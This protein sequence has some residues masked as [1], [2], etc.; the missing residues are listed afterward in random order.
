MVFVCTALG[1]VP[2]ITGTGG[3][4]GNLKDAPARAPRR[5][6]TVV[7][8]I[9]ISVS[10]GFVRGLAAKRLEFQKLEYWPAPPAIY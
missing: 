5:D 6:I 7:G 4:V 9:E 10:S 1:P 3:Q 8:E 2:V